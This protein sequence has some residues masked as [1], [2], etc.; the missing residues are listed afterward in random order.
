MHTIHQVLHIASRGC[1]VREDPCRG[2]HMLRQTRKG[3]PEQVWTRLRERP[4]GRRRRTACGVVVEGKRVWRAGGLHGLWAGLWI[5]W[6]LLLCCTWAGRGSTFLAQDYLDNILQT[7][8]AVKRLSNV[9]HMPEPS[10][11]A[12]VSISPQPPAPR[13]P[14]GQALQDNTGRQA[15]S[16]DGPVPGQWV[17]GPASDL[18]SRGF[19]N[20]PDTWGR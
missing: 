13:P 16:T 8:E 1:P 11:G 18:S 6:V 9:R 14:P 4:R 3:G 17:G 15:G 20:P 5:V 19:N 10:V 7:G 12:W 2:S